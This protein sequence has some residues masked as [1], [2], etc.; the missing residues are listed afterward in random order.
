MPEAA[1]TKSFTNTADDRGAPPDGNQ[2]TV[3]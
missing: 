1:V 2:S 3:R